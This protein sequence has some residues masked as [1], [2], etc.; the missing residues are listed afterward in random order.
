LLT[1]LTTSTAPVSGG[2]ATATELQNTTSGI[3]AGLQSFISAQPTVAARPKAGL[4]WV[5]LDEQFKI[6]KD[7][8]GNIIAS[9]YSGFEQVGPSGVTTL[10]VK[11]NL[12]VAKSGYL[13][14]YTSN[15]T[16]NIDVYFDNL[17][18]SHT[19]G[20][21]LEKTHYYP[22]GLTMAGLS[23]KAASAL[24]NKYKYNGKELQSKEFSDGSG[25]EWSD[26]GAR[27]YDA[28][29][30][31]WHVVDPLAEQM[32]RYS[33]YNYCFNNPI[34]FVDPDG[35]EAIDPKTIGAD[36]LTNEQWIESSRP[37][38][39]PGLVNL[40]QQSNKEKIRNQYGVDPYEWHDDLDG[41]KSKSTVISTLLRCAKKLLTAGQLYTLAIGEG[42]NLFLKYYDD[43]NAEVDGF[44]FLGVDHFGSEANALRNG[45]YIP[46][47][48]NEG[49]EYKVK[50]NVNEKGQ[51]VL[52]ATFKNLE[53]A[54]IA[55]SGVANQR[56]DLALAAGKKLG[57]GK[58]NTD[59]VM[60]WSYIF[61]QSPY[62]SGP[63]SL[64]QASSWSYSSFK[65]NTTSQNPTGIP[66]KS[67][68]RLATWNYI[69]LEGLFKN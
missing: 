55:F 18:V 62:G 5:L 21:I 26:Y 59:Q 22:F 28:Q 44:Q 66:S 1:L 48:F 19:R 64:S 15:E 65:F 4:S 23:S 25:L 40:F 67:L 45:G 39:D 38:S 63:K 46:N 60:F 51:T 7:A 33:V 3:N 49:D 32:R 31:R 43:P 50:S 68:R 52:A 37:G 2:K 12:T 42:L 56:A 58:P 29:V 13:Y 9:G 34:K 14:I 17:Q 20:P 47:D 6:A 24:E 57:Y 53:S 8:N 11:A 30:G 61:F 27:M 69:V 41:K 54:L 16:T 36:G 10:H 35:M